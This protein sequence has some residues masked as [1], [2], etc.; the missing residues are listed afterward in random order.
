MSVLLTHLFTYLLTYSLTC[1]KAHKSNRYDPITRTLNSLPPHSCR[2]TPLPAV[3][4]SVCLQH[5]HQQQQRPRLELHALDGLSF[6]S[7]RARFAL[8]R[9]V[10]EIAYAI[11]RRTSEGAGDDGGRRVA[12]Q[13][14]AK[15][16]HA[17]G[18]W[19]TVTWQEVHLPAAAIVGHAGSR[20]MG[21]SATPRYKSGGNE[22]T[23]CSG[24]VVLR[25]CVLGPMKLFENIHEPLIE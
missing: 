19:S 17:A 6:S 8:R 5:Q 18:G 23:T 21:Q 9:T 15:H 1:R 24:M 4:Q 22:I 13:I 7:I 20:S 16:R 11:R 3:C 25:N 10:A 12:G 14:K 2:Y